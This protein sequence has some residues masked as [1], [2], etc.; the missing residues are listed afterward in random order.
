MSSMISYHKVIIVIMPIMFISLKGISRAE[1]DHVTELYRME[2]NE[3]QSICKV[4]GKAS[5][6]KS[7]IQNHAE[8]YMRVYDMID[9]SA[10]LHFQPDNRYIYTYS[11]ISCWCLVKQLLVVDFILHILQRYFMSL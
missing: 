4:C 10:A 2:K 7:N 1:I 6:K 5:N 11:W 9:V 3:G 8:I